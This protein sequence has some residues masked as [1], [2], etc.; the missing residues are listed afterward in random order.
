MATVRGLKVKG[1]IKLEDIKHKLR[2][3]SM[4]LQTNSENILKIYGYYLKLLFYS[5]KNSHK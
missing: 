1:D 2:V 3:G 4:W 5:S